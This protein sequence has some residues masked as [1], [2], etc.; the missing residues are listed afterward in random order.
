MKKNKIAALFLSGVLLATNAFCWPTKT[1]TPIN[2]ETEFSFRHRDGF[3]EYNKYYNSSGGIIKGDLVP[4]TFKV[5]EPILLQIQMHP[6]S[7][8]SSKKDKERLIPV[9]IAIEKMHDIE[10][11][12][13]GGLT[14]VKLE[15]DRDGN[16][17]YSF[18]IKNDAGLHPSIALKFIPAAAGEA[19]ITVT[20]F[21]SDLDNSSGKKGACQTVKFSR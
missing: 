20:Y 8:K 10:V 14:N 2:V 13:V 5:G 17:R 9:E 21:E 15:I 4:P 7:S 18:F 11:A 12:Q 16:P 19:V 3:E 6:T 1:S